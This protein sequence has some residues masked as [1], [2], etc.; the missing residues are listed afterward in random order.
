MRFNLD[1]HPS[2][3]PRELIHSPPFSNN[4]SS[5]DSGKLVHRVVLAASFEYSFTGKI[6]FVVITNIGTR[7]DMVFHTGD[8]ASHDGKL[9]S[10]PVEFTLALYSDP[11]FL[12]FFARVLNKACFHLR[13]SFFLR[14]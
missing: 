4:H 7:H 5:D 12:C 14:R 1:I 6:L 9:N 13:S 3:S 2:F 8:T 10:S 11:Q